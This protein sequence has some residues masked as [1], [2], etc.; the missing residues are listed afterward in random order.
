MLILKKSRLSCVARLASRKMLVCLIGAALL[1]TPLFSTLP[2]QGQTQAT[3]SRQEPI[4]GQVINRYRTAR[5]GSDQAGKRQQVAPPAWAADAQQRS[6]AYCQENRERFHLRDAGTELELVDAQQDDLGQT[7]IRLA[8]TQH[9]MEVFGGQLVA[10]LAGETV[11]EINGRTFAAQDVET[12]PV[13]D[14]AQAIRLAEQ[15]LGYPGQFAGPPEARLVI[16]PRRIVA[17]DETPGATLTWQV[18]LRIEDGTAATAHHRYFIN[19]RD[20]SVVWHYDSLPHASG[21]GHSLYQG[22]VTLSTTQSSSRYV[23]MDGQQANAATTDMQNIEEPGNAVLTLGNLFASL[24]NVWGNG[25]SYHRQ[26]AAVD[27]H[28]GAM[29]TWDYFLNV[30]GRRGIDGNGYRIISRIHYGNGYNNAYYYLSASSG[31][32]NGWMRGPAGTDFD[33]YL[34]KW[35]GS[36]WVKLAASESGSSEEHIS[37]YGAPGYYIWQVISYSGSGSYQFWLQRP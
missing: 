31:Y 20:G 29:K 28:F 18:E 22:T 1:S 37:Y 13:L 8:Q 9:G 26:S 32:H 34:W 10:Q 30:H 25:S 27:A 14:S 11:L 16:L 21:V 3:D 7:H 5:S 33:L 35:D 4:R 23:L 2:V 24:N 36:Q 19:A 6:L 15:A 12:T 17:D